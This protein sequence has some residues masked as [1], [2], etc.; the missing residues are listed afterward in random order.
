M[1]TSIETASQFVATSSG[2]ALAGVG[3]ATQTDSAIISDSTLLPLSLFIGGIAF[4]AAITWKSANA[5]SRL[6]H[7][8]ENIESRLDR[9][10]RETGASAGMETKIDMAESAIRDFKRRKRR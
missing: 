7:K 6:L 3:V 9:L 5:K 8:L 1:I 2:L 10:E 4:T